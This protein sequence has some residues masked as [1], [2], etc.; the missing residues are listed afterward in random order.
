MPESGLS[1]LLF[2]M[3]AIS[4]LSVATANSKTDEMVRRASAATVGAPRFGDIGPVFHL[5]TLCGDGLKGVRSDTALA[6]F[7]NWRAKKKSTQLRG[8]IAFRIL[9]D[10][11]KPHKTTAAF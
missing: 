10:S 4:A 3:P 2:N 8:F 7:S 9:G 11:I 6:D 1:A 5:Q